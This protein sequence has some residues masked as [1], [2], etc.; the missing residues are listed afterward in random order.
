MNNKYNIIDSR[1]LVPKEVY[2]SMESIG[3]WTYKY[4]TKEDKNESNYPPA[5]TGGVS[6]HS[7]PKAAA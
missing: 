2:E 6:T 7:R 1:D 3:S 5:L 4:L